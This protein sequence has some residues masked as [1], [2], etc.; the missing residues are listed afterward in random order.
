[1]L[2]PE[3][4]FRVREVLRETAALLTRKTDMIFEGE[5]GRFE[6]ILVLPNT[7]VENARV[8]VDKIRSTL[9]ECIGKDLSLDNFSLTIDSL[10]TTHAPEAQR[11]R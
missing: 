5:K 1:M 9:A 2:K 7:P 8:V 11:T 6:L 3:A 10:G 4:E